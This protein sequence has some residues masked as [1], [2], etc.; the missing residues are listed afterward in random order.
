MN[1][2]YDKKL[3]IISIILT[4]ILLTTLGLYLLKND[5]AILLDENIMEYIHG[6]ITEFGQKTMNGITFFGSTVFIAAFTG[7]LTIYFIIRKH[8]LNS[9]YILLSSG[10]TAILNQFLKSIFTRTRPEIYFTIVEKGYSFPSGH[11]MVGM[12]FYSYIFYLLRKK[13]PRYDRVFLAINFIIV[14]FIGFSRIYL[15]VHWPSDVIMGLFLGYSIYRII[16]HIN[17]Y[18]DKKLS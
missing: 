6:R 13:Y 8:Y 4:A 17:E 1:L 11:S 2:K 9:I 15:G 5:K 7:V 16:R 14:S 12:A 18:S 10:G 3:S